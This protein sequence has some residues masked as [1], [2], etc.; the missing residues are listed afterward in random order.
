MN[1]AGRLWPRR[2]WGELAI[3]LGTANTVACLRR[4]RISVGEP[5][6][7]TIERATGRTVAVGAEAKAMLGR[8]PE[9]L[10][11]VRPLRRGVIADF[12]ATQ[13]L[14]AAFMDRAIA[15]RPW[16]RLAVVITVPTGVTGIER[17]AAREA[18]L[19]AGARQA[20]ALEAPVAAALG[21]GLGNDVKPAAIIDVGAGTTE[22]AAVAM[23]GIVT[24][25]A[26]RIAGD[27]MDAAIASYLRR[28][29]NLLVGE[30]TAEAIKVEVGSA[31][32]LG[33]DDRTT[34]ARG[35]DLGS[36]LPKAIRVGAG[37]IRQA[38]AEPIRAI[39]RA[40]VSG[41]EAMGPELASDISSAGLVLVGGGALLP[42]LDRLVQLET[43]MPVRR[44]D[45]VVNCAARG[46]AR[47]LDMGDRV[48]F[49]DGY[50]RGRT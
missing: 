11:V 8:T 47:A 13:T 32:A 5:T 49:S 27:D 45:D 22:I 9:S 46:A 6:V 3:D 20:V 40:V 17:H 36:G 33:D 50:P 26:V 35:R 15:R 14:L 28:E 24:S 25:H 19:G 43:G 10:E 4:G 7:I 41:I 2:G 29:F 42:G 23:G 37:Q 44:A 16:S 39:T 12:E 30:L 38:M 34:I 1:G 21:L 18:A 48:Q 31:C